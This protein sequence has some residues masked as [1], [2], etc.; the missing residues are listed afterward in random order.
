MKAATA[1]ESRGRS[2]MMRC[3]LLVIGLFV[4]VA[5]SAAGSPEP[6]SPPESAN[7]EIESDFD[8]AE[9]LRKYG[10]EPKQ[11]K[12]PSWRKFYEL[13]EPDESQRKRQ[14]GYAVLIAKI[15]QNFSGFGTKPVKGAV[16][17]AVE[18]DS[19]NDLIKK[20]ISNYSGEF[21]DYTWRAE[22]IDTQTFLVVCEITLDGEEYDFKFQVN[23]ELETCRYE[24]GTAY[25]KLRSNQRKSSWL[26]W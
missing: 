26:P 8:P 10:G 2:T 5:S 1:F 24:G 6:A 17:G 13:D 21:T 9:F 3:G 4:H 25:E 22:P 15:C 11:E 20:W 7:Q 18:G 16:S 23:T 12:E 19:N 14:Q